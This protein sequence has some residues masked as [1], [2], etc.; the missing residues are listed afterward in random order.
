MTPKNLSPQI[1]RLLEIM[2]LLRTQEGGCP[3]HRK[4]TFQTIVSYTL[5]EA[6]EVEDA[7]ARQDYV[8]LCAE[9]G[10]LL[11]QVIYHAQLAEEEGYF[12]FADVAEGLIK[13]LEERHP[14]IFGTKEQR[15]TGFDPDH[16]FKIK[17]QEKVKR[18]AGQAVT[19]ED[20]GGFYLDCVKRIGP[21]DKEALALQNQAA[22]VGFEWKNLP[23]IIDKFVEEW[24]ELQQAIK[25]G[26]EEDIEEEFGDLYFALLN[27]ARRLKIDPEKALRHCNEKM[28][29]RFGIIEQILK[30]QG[31][32]LKNSTFKEMEALWHTAKQL[33]SKS[34][35]PSQHA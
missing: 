21:A 18:Y 13:K 3:W 20:P 35:P 32:T 26:V 4:Q 34:L 9:L 28:R 1:Q 27:I 2:A 23:P 29:R 7:V 25:E 24:G 22:Q 14:H 10:D 12:C 30:H 17:A 19:L 6:Y 16:W 31:K 33:E 11:F 5:E 8:D 15:Q